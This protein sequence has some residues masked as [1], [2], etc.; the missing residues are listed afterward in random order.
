MNRHAILSNPR[1]EHTVVLDLVHCHQPPIDIDVVQQEYGNRNANLP[2]CCRTCSM[3]WG[4]CPSSHEIRLRC[5][6]ARPRMSSTQV[7]R[8]KIKC[9]RI[10]S[11][12]LVSML[13]VLAV[14]MTVALRLGC[15]SRRHPPAE[16]AGAQ[17]S[18]P[19]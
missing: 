5:A 1:N 7:S 15:G 6:D 2:L 18:D 3:Q 16:D 10:A 13:A 8:N 11:P 9:S 19:V 4:N 14:G 12:V 17:V